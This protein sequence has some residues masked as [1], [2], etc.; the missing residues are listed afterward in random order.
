[1]STGRKIVLALVV[2]AVVVYGI[3]AQARSS[4]RKE[5]ARILDGYV[6]ATGGA[7]AYRAIRTMAIRGKGTYLGKPVTIQEYRAVPCQSHTVLWQEDEDG[8]SMGTDGKTAWV[9]SNRRPEILIGGRRL[10]A[11]RNAA[12]DGDVRWQEFFTSAE[13]VGTTEFAGR[14]C[15]KLIMTQEIGSPKTRYYDTQTN[16]LLG[17]EYDMV[18]PR[19]KTPPRIVKTLGDYRPFGGVVLPTRQTEKVQGYEVDLTIEDVAINVTIPQEQ[20]ALPDAVKILQVGLPG[21]LK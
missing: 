11:F 7:T 18:V 21:Y 17:E 20:F 16:Y 15:Y 13:C 6:Q 2:I 9:I 8:V 19:G 14:T 4:R 10:D 1:M 12:I 3:R 5:A